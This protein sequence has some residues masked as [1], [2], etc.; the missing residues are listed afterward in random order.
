MQELHVSFSS[1]GM[2]P[3]RT[4]GQRGVRGVPLQRSTAQG[5]VL[6]PS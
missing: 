2:C 4:P 6:G 1:T 3:S 5:P